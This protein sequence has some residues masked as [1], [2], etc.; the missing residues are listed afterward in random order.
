ML[1]IL[2]CVNVMHEERCIVLLV[3]ARRYNNV[4]PLKNKRLTFFCF[5][6]VTSSTFPC[7]VYCK[8]FTHNKQYRVI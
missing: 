1:F 7:R 8:S 5:A 3:R 6:L 2:S 4:H